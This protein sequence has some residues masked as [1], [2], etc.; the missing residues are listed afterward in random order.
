MDSSKT[1]GLLLSVGL[2]IAAAVQV[3]GLRKLEN[4][5]AKPDDLVKRS[6]DI[7][8]VLLIAGIG[9]TLYYGYNWLKGEG[10]L[11]FLE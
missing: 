11:S 2:L 4:A 8:V 10:H 5:G 9:G 1:L 6:K 3:D 7:S